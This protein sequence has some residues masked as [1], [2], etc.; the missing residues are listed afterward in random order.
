M[1]MKTQVHKVDSTRNPDAHLKPAKE[2]GAHG[3]H[4]QVNGQKMFHDLANESPVVQKMAL[5]HTMVNQQVSN[6]FP[7][8]PPTV[9]LPSLPVTTP[10]LETAPVQLVKN[11]KKRAISE[12]LKEEA[13]IE[14]E[15]K[16]DVQTVANYWARMVV[17]TKAKGSDVKPSD[18]VVL[19]VRISPERRATKLD[20]LQGDHL[21]AW[22]VMYRYW[23]TRLTGDMPTVV[24]NLM[25]LLVDDE[26]ADTVTENSALRAK[27]LQR[28]QKIKA[29]DAPANHYLGWLEDAVSLFVEANQAG[30]FAVH[31]KASGG[32]SEGESRQAL[33]WYNAMK[34]EA[35]K[36]EDEMVIREKALNLI[37]IAGKNL[38]EPIK[39]KVIWTW[40]TML[41]SMFP[42]L[43]GIFSKT[44]DSHTFSNKTV[45]WWKQEWEKYLNQEDTNQ[46]TLA[47]L[48]LESL[49]KAAKEVVD[50]EDI[51]P[52]G[53]LVN[54]G[55]KEEG[56]DISLKA[57][58]VQIRNLELPEK[59]RARTQFVTT[60][61]S[62]TLAWTYVRKSLMNRFKDK[63]A[64]ETLENLQGLVQADKKF[65]DKHPGDFG[66]DKRLEHLDKVITELKN[67]KKALE[68]WIVD[69]NEAIVEYIEVNQLLE[70][71]TYKTSGRAESH[72]EASSNKAFA[73][74][75][76]T[77]GTYSTEQLTEHAARYLDLGFVYQPLLE[78]L[79]HYDTTA[80]AMD[81]SPLKDLAAGTTLEDV[82]SKLETKKPQPPTLTKKKESPMPR[83]EPKNALGLLAKLDKLSKNQVEKVVGNMKLKDLRELEQLADGAVG[84]FEAK[85][86]ESNEEVV[87]NS[88]LKRRRDFHFQDSEMYNYLNELGSEMNVKDKITRFQNIRTN[89]Q[90]SIALS[91][92]FKLEQYNELKELF[93]RLSDPQKL[94]AAVLEKSALRL[95]KVLHE[96]YSHM[97][98]FHKDYHT[99]LGKEKVQTALVKK[100][101]TAPLNV[102]DNM[103]GA[104]IKVY[105]L[106][107][108]TTYKFFIEGF[109]KGV[110]EESADIAKKYMK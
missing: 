82:K 105:L 18:L 21:V 76:K 25:K 99:E 56:K 6:V 107:N 50:D 46:K 72:G 96:F 68:F 7:T 5:L 66:L 62:H 103:V 108:E 39:G 34:Q 92:E 91:H 20:V 58:E 19:D 28:L 17:R 93:L 100:V 67:E 41:G 61:G 45:S 51:K 30:G 83:P 52:T 89:M 70:S 43:K 15:E 16:D 10:S 59:I 97:A 13:T 1:N 81:Y 57:D 109:V 42:N 106:G 4:S 12:T 95:E 79:I 32:K 63:T 26:V 48:K 77:K 88:S 2:M 53:V 87:E 65:A 80:K 3:E 55:P 37:D 98:Y 94:V 24:N 47:T 75:G 35:I 22:S 44:L 102:K 110:E 86:K 78:A 36:S 74:E 33:E 69:I 54:A 60:Q 23:Q 104:S 31:G 29:G 71:S 101:L 73:E 14:I 27:A 84:Y 40:Y 11:T 64:N 90:N 8:M 9:D 38:T 49:E 85:S